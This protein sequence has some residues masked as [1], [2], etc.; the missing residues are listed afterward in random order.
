ME[1]GSL[2]CTAWR[3]IVDAVE[4]VTVSAAHCC[5]EAWGW[6]VWRVVVECDCVGWS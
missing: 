5:F 4:P 6:T 3:L 2:C 1:C